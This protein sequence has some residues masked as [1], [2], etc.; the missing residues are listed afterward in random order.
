MKRKATIRTVGLKRREKGSTRM[1]LP[2]QY[3]IDHQNLIRACNER[4][5]GALEWCLLLEAYEKGVFEDIL[6]LLA[7]IH[8]V[9]PAVYVDNL[10]AYLIRR[11][12]LRLK[13]RR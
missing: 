7:D 9:E 6:S 5:V 3:E 8:D 2:N 1:G 13:T 10:I 12:V 4:E 11:K